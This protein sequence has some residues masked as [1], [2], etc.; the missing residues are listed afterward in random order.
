MKNE[1]EQM[2]GPVTE[3]EFEEAKKYSI[4]KLKLA[5][6][7]ENRK[8]PDWYLG[9]LIADTIKENRFSDYTFRVSFGGVI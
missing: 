2:I 9:A 7:R 6:E 4:R 5:E 8:F 1:V 3:R